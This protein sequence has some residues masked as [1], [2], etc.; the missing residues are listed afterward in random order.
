MQ[1]NNE[2]IKERKQELVGVE[3]ALKA[4]TQTV[5]QLDARRK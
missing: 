1:K 4:K 2:L 5:K 3:K